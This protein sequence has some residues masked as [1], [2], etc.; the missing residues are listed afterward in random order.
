MYVLLSS[1]SIRVNFKPDYFFPRAQNTVV[2][3][4][5]VVNNIKPTIT[6]VPEQLK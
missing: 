3:F 6:S 1:V 4:V 5:P 2:T